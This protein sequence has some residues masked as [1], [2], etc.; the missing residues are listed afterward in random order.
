MARTDGMQRWV[1]PD[2]FICFLDKMSNGQFMGYEEHPVPGGFLCPLVCRNT[3][4]E[5]IDALTQWF[6]EKGSH[7]RA[8]R[9]VVETA[10]C[11]RMRRIRAVLDT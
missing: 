6:E 4:Q 8:E 2:G 3:E 9:S 7:F 11:R 1:S 10:E 5:T